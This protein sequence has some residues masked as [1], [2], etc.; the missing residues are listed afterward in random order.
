MHLLS[1]TVRNYRLHRERTVEFDRALTLIGG[2]NESGK[3]TLIEA[4]H[5]A[6]FFRANAG[7]QVRTQ[8]VSLLHGAPPEVEVRFVAGGREYH[9]FKRFSGQTGTARLSDSNGKVLQGDAA[10]Q[11]LAELLAV[12]EIIGGHGATN[13]L[14]RQWAHLWV[15]QGSS[16]GDPCDSDGLPHDDL[17]QR[18]QAEGGAVV[19]QSACDIRVASGFKESRAGLFT[20]SGQPRAGSDLERAEREVADTEQAWRRASAVVTELQQAMEDFSSAGQTIDEAG[21]SL[22]RIRQEMTETR[23]KLTQLEKLRARETVQASDAKNASALLDTLEKAEEQ[24]S[25]R[26]QEI[27][28]RTRTLAP[29]KELLRK[30]SDELDD[31]RR[32]A[33]AAAVAY[34]VAVQASRSA[35]DRH[36]LARAWVEFFAKKARLADL[37]RAQDRA[38]K[39]GKEFA[40]LQRELAALP[41]VSAKDLKT[42][43][44]LETAQR[45]AE[46][47]LQAMAAGIELLAADTAVRLGGEVLP[48]GKSVTVAQTTDLEIG[49]GV[50]VRIHP[51]GGDSL[52][53]AR[54]RVRETRE[55]FADAIKR[56]GVSSVSEASEILFK[57]GD[58]EARLEAKGKALEEADLDKLH[59]DFATAEGEL[60]KVETEVARRK[61]TLTAEEAPND[62]E[63]ARSRESE[64][65]A[66]VEQAEQKEKEVLGERDAC[67]AALREAEAK[68]AAEQAALETESR[69]LEAA[70]AQLRLLVENHGDDVAREKALASARSAKA[71][72]EEALA[73]TRKEVAAMQPDLLVADQI[74]QER[75]LTGTETVLQNARIKRGLAAEKLRFSG[76]GDPQA[77]LELAAAR[78]EAARERR[79]SIARKADAIRLLDDLFS[80]EQ[81]KLEEHFTQPLIEKISGYLECIFG[82]GAK[83][84]VS[85]D[86]GRFGSIR[87]IRAQGGPAF[88]FAALSGGAREQVAAAI[89][90]AIA[91]VLASESGEG[92]PVVFDDAFTWSDPDRLEKLQRMLD[93]AAGRGLQVIVLTCT[94]T[95][96]TTLGAR[97]IALDAPGFS[98]GMISAIDAVASGTDASDSMPSASSGRESTASWVT[99]KQRQQFLAA[100]Q[101]AGGKAGNQTLNAT[102][103]W[104]DTTYN[105]VKEDLLASGKINSGRGRGGSVSLPDDLTESSLN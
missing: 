85:M 28:K 82:R 61:E 91:E 94:P 104:D 80:E 60:A 3:S 2:P 84:T 11:R 87:F 42:L 35:R 23:T 102:L 46:A 68:L 90:L 8:M 89:R 45:E 52:A 69:E 7:G 98:P 25:T 5:R 24:I 6:L 21:R 15:W 40:A 54:E 26:R 70:T 17:V 38:R 93:R 99:E 1:A 92:L 29:R 65:R 88:P 66:R 83:A 47:A 30:I 49:D 44:N 55:A 56:L 58:L 32:R 97:Q 62:E 100:L 37:E 41:A 67:A 86:E 43:Q 73:A 95:D 76:T 27:E 96:Y 75:A 81:S 48:P 10:E 36:E 105:A 34:D 12:D 77:D 101:T 19:A 64:E 72:V 79:D 63:E 50:R 16:S 20:K 59:R 71:A 53:A 57:R 9:L 51:G 18:L 33:A 103:G 78:M 74:R 13:R 39:L 31:T 4:I 14:A 22:E